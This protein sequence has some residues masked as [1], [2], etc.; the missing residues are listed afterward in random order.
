MTLDRI[1]QGK[2]LAL[3]KYRLDTKRLPSSV[4]ES[5][6]K[7]AADANA[8]L[9]DTLLAPDYANFTYDCQRK[10]P[11]H[12]PNDEL[13]GLLE[14]I[15]RHR[16]L[17]GNERSALAYSRAISALRAYPRK[18]TR[19]DEAHAIKAIGDKIS[20]MIGEY[21]R[22]GAICEVEKVEAD[23][24]TNILGELTRVY[25][26]G[27]KVAVKLVQQGIASIEHLKEAFSAGQV[28]LTTDQAVGLRYLEDLE[29]TY[30]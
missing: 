14:T 4:A 19:V 23:A 11:L 17:T 5:S 18:V 2:R 8:D 24:D 26:I 13:V 12:G 15:E 10:T 9:S 16:Y 29:Q 3:D 22:H 30:H 20:M 6:D 1:E 27:P 7:R 28:N 25:G 21:L